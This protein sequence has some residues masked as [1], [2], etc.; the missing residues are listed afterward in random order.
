MFCLQFF[1]V[2]P[3]AAVREISGNDVKLYGWHPGSTF[4]MFYLF[5]P[6]ELGGKG[7]VFTK[8]QA[9]VKETGRSYEE[10]VK[11]VRTASRSRPDNP[12]DRP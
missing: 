5:G 1:A 4:A 12:A 8:V 11:E 6:E 2:V 3:I 9:I 7:D 10:V